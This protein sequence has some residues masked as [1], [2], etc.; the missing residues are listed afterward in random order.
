MKNVETFSLNT[1][2]IKISVLQKNLLQ[3]VD[4][5]LVCLAVKYFY[6]DYAFEAIFQIQTI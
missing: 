4:N 3:F 2:E 6:S 5:S 1:I